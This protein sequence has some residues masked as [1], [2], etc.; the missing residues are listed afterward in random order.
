MQY[1]YPAGNIVKFSGRLAYSADWPVASS[2]P[3]LGLEV[4]LTCVA[5]GGNLCALGAEQEVLPPASSGGVALA[6]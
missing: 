3:L 2:D 5:P 4:V 6:A 1:V